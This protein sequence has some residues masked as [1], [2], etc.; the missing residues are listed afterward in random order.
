MANVTPNL[1]CNAQVIS[2]VADGA[3]VAGKFCK[4][5][6]TDG[7]VKAAVSGDGEVC[8]GIFTS[9]VDSGD[10]VGVAIAGQGVLLVDAVSVAIAAGNHLGASAAYGVKKTANNAQAGA[11]ALEPCAIDAGV[12]R[13]DIQRHQVG[14]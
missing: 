6:G 12:I 13:V 14:A 4:F 3:S 2:V 9:T 10:N 11:Y 7:T 5:T 8:D 1:F